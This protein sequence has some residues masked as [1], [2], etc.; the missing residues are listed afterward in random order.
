MAATSPCSVVSC[1]V[2][3]G[4]TAPSLARARVASSSP[5]G[6]VTWGEGA[7]R[8][9]GVLDPDRGVG[10]GGVAVLLAHAHRRPAGRVGGGDREVTDP[11]PGRVQ[12]VGLGLQRVPAGGR[13]GGVGVDPLGGHQVGGGVLERHHA[14]AGWRG[15]GA[16]E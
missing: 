9:G 10:L 3:A 14:A 12:G 16:P 13:R 11:L 1:Q 2:S 5:A 15:R 4:D 6:P 8:V 7:G